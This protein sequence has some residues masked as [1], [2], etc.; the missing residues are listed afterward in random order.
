MQGEISLRIDRK[1]DFENIG[2][3]YIHQFVGKKKK[4]GNSEHEIVVSNVSDD[5]IRFLNDHYRNYELGSVITKEKL[6]FRI[7][8]CA[9][10]NLYGVKLNPGELWK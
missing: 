9:R 5:L 2:V 10:Q 4:A 8:S 7:S 6:L 3:F 1:P